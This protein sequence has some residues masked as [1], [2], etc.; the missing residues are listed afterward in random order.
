MKSI[1]HRIP[2]GVRRA[3]NRAL[4]RSVRY[5][6]PYVDWAEANAM[7]QGYSAPEILRT[8]R[9]ACERVLSGQARFEQDGV[10]FD[11]EPMPDATIVALLLAAGLTG[12]RLSVIDFGGGLASHYLR[13]APLLSRLPALH[14]CV[15]EQPHFV[16]A[17][18]ELFAG[19][20]VVNFESELDRASLTKPTAIIV[21]SVLQYLDDP[22]RTLGQLVR[23]DAG[24][25]AIGRT[26]FSRDDQP[27]FFAQHIPQQIYSAS[28][29]LQSLSAQR[30]GVAL[31]Q[32]GYEALSEMPTDDEP[33]RCEGFRADYRSSIWVR[34][35]P[36]T[37]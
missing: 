36:A 21:S 20:E 37:P 26:P 23:L 31:R 29:P 16:Q 28:Y 3:V 15:V 33:I 34:H 5:T 13:W 35:R 4:G 2:K 25:I 14:W 32:G 30:V 24:V 6:G 18:R 12:G 22:Y 9:A 19:H 1:A 7:T 11:T 10:A 27:H 17:G 8:V